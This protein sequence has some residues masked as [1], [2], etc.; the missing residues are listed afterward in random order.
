MYVHASKARIRNREVTIDSSFNS[1]AGIKHV[2]IT[3][4]RGIDPKE[5]TEEAAA[6]N[7]LL[8]FLSTT[9]NQFDD[10]KRTRAKFAVVIVGINNIRN[11][12]RGLT[13][14]QHVENFLAFFRAVLLALPDATVFWASVGNAPRHTLCY[15]VLAQV[16]RILR[17]R[18]STGNA[19]PERLIFEDLSHDCT[20]KDIRDEYFHW[21]YPYAAEIMRR[22]GRK[23]KDFFAERE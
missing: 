6:V 4:L 21:D 18:Q 20:D 11:D 7:G 22:C 3:G 2:A 12:P 5:P 9:D 14:E 15:T 8:N 1:V 10:V 17:E 19:W 16:R 23:L 13:P